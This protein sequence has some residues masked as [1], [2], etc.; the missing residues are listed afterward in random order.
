MPV[1]R[2]TEALEQIERQ[3]LESHGD[4][5][6][7]CRALNISPIDLNQ[8]T[9][10]DPE[11]ASRIHQ[12]KLLGWQTLESEAI[13]RATGYDEEV[14]FQGEMVGYKR[15]YSDGLLTTLLK[16]RVDGHQPE[17]NSGIRALAVQVNV[18]PRASTYEEWQAQRAAT[19]A[20]P[21]ESIEVAEYEEVSPE[22]KAAYEIMKP[23]NGLPDWL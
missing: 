11:V 21:M 12:A 13:R 17:N 5:Y 22:A 16:A 8:W 4:L 20:P 10:S 2:T 6:A 9:Q 19:L 15:T 18:M 3:L 7:A 1:P 14:W 23:T